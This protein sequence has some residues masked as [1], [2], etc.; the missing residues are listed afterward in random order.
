MNGPEEIVKRISDEVVAAMARAR[1]PPLTDGEILVG[2]RYML[3]GKPP[4]RVVFVPSPGDF[5][6]KDVNRS[7]SSDENKGSRAARSL[8]TE[9]V[10]FE[11]HV[12]GPAMPP[13]S[14]LGFTVT[15]ALA[16]E[17]IR[18]ALTTYAGLCTIGPTDWPGQRTDDSQL[19]AGSHEYVFRLAIATPVQDTAFGY[20]A[21][22]VAFVP[23]LKLNGEAA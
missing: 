6:A 7:S 8:V 19:V 20:A 17:V 14:K 3:N 4:P 18:S 10:T 22:D 9:F 2:R 13:E 1:V 23:V 5:A 16:R 15:H 21:E 12:F 11:V